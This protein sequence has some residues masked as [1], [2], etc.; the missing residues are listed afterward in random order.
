MA[1]RQ[2][3]NKGSKGKPGFQPVVGKGIKPPTTIL[4]MKSTQTNPTST[5]TTVG[6][7]TMPKMCADPSVCGVKVHRVGTVCKAQQLM[8]KPPFQVDDEERLS[9]FTP[10]EFVELSLGESEMYPFLR[11]VEK[12]KL[13]TRMDKTG[14]RMPN[15]L[16]LEADGI[17]IDY[18]TEE[19][20]DG[21]GGSSSAIR[22]V[23]ISVTDTK[24]VA[25]HIL[26]SVQPYPKDEDIQALTNLLDA[27]NLNKAGTLEYELEDFGGGDDHIAN[28]KI[29][30]PV[31]KEKIA[32]FLS[33][34]PNSRKLLGDNLRNSNLDAASKY[35]VGQHIRSDNDH[36]EGTVVKVRPHPNPYYNESYASALVD[37][38]RG[39]RM[40]VATPKQQ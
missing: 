16:S 35:L 12:N 5:T 19:Y 9:G 11:S 28:I 36:I 34:D 18:E 2:G 24:K 3:Q 22:D 21:E 1:G 33:L 10:E 37:D 4:Q 15:L 39:T 29:A 8:N 31:L 40:W 27:S 17:T 14:L 23:K 25:E 26:Q 7:Q 30:N 6:H 13:Q 32:G 20:F 38:K